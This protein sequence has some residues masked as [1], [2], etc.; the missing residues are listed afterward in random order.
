[1]IERM[2]PACDFYYV[3]LNL[4]WLLDRKLHLVVYFGAKFR[5]SEILRRINSA[6]LNLRSQNFM[7][8]L[9]DR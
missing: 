5:Q 1:M 8:Y 9:L 3:V 6:I 4:E 2:F 7:I